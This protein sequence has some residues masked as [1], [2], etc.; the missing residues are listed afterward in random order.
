MPLAG[1]NRLAK[2]YVENIFVWN[3][4]PILYGGFGVLLS[5]VQMG[6][7]G[8]ML[9]Q[10]DFLGGLGNLEG[11]FLLGIVSIVYS[12]AI[13]V[14]PFVAKRI[15]SG[16][17]G[18]TAVAMVG[19]AVTALTAGAAGIE[20]AAAGVAAA[21]AAS[22]G[23]TSAGA[24]SGA[25][26]A[27]AARALPASSGGNLPAPPQPT[28][29]AAPSPASGFDLSTSAPTLEGHA[30]LIRNSI[31]EA[32]GADRAETG[33]S[34]IAT[35]VATEASDV[36]HTGSSGAG[37][38]TSSNARPPASQRRGPSVH[39]YNLGTWGAYHA[40][41]IAAGGIAKATKRSATEE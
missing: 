38:R 24:S 21:R 18:S 8:Q 5:A 25:A 11:A 36:A 20:G 6:Q 2:A 34:G 17:V 33:D 10:N 40:A 14:I 26:L 13:A 27:G 19:T 12:L 39:R 41:R 9:N 4:W 37:T 1:A 16:D 32:M 3:A 30:E 15:V 22:A 35:S 7:V 23:G 29:I 28:P 31:G